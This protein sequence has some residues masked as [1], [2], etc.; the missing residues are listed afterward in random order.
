MD[1]RSAEVERYTQ[2]LLR[3]KGAGGPWENG[4]VFSGR[5]GQRGFGFGTLFKSLGRAIIRTVANPKVR[6]TLIKGAVDLGRKVISERKK[7]TQA[8][9]ETGE[10]VLGDLFTKKQG[11]T[12]SVRKRKTKRTGDIFDSSWRSKRTKK[13]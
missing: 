12:G 8:L 13:V 10:Q 1:N 9:L 2:C 4:V 11:G 3:Q 6:D 7:P 5:R